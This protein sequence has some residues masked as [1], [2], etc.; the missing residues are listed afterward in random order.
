VSNSP[1]DLLKNRMAGVMANAV[2][3]VATSAVTE[4][5]E[6]L[7]NGIKS[8]LHGMIGGASIVA[9][10][11][12]QEPEE[13]EDEDE[14]EIEETEDEETEEIDSPIPIA[15]NA[16][17]KGKNLECAAAV[18][19]LWGT[20]DTECGDMLC[21]P[22]IIAVFKNGLAFCGSM[23]QLQEFCE[24]N[25][26]DEDVDVYGLDSDNEYDSEEIDSMKVGKDIMAY[27][28]A[29]LVA[30]NIEDSEE[31]FR[32][33]H[34][35]EKATVTKVVQMIPFMENVPLTMCGVAQAIIYTAKKGG[36][37]ET[38][39]HEFGEDSGEK[40]LMYALPTPENEKW[41][42]SILI[43]GGNMRV[44]DRGIVD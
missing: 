43:H 10:P 14:D 30:N 36:K 35:D 17:G 6:L 22:D 32:G 23:S 4:G 26:L 9:N 29:Y 5:T 42:R 24:N 34:W 2:S 40:P 28:S 25:D 18:W 8:K 37:V 16:F 11:K 38:Y 31:A 13:T 39:I 19:K 27:V 7:K 21:E 41:P 44:E 3:D 12:K 1:I 33:F 15:F 20:R